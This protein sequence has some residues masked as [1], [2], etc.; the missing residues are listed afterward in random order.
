MHYNYTVWKRRPCWSGVMRSI[1]WQLAKLIGESVKHYQQVTVICDGHQSYGPRT[2]LWS[3]L[4]TAA[5]RRPGLCPYCAAHAARVVLCI[6]GRFSSGTSDSL[7][8]RV[9]NPASWPAARHHA[10]RGGWR[11]P[12]VDGRGVAVLLLGAPADD[13]RTTRPAGRQALWLY[14]LTK[15]PS[16][17]ASFIRGLSSDGNTTRQ[18]TGG[19]F[20]LARSYTRSI[21]AIVMDQIENTLIEVLGSSFKVRFHY[22]MDALQGTMTYNNSSTTL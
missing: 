16:A 4:V 1:L 15:S 7:V 17:A 21:I 2:I 19:H 5:I 14:E 20:A 11:G 10:S 18:A 12:T 6:F 9:I 22:D 3:N 13:R 8:R